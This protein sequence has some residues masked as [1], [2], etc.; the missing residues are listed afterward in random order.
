M[1]IK[2]KEADI[3][4]KM[5]VMPVGERLMGTAGEMRTGPVTMEGHPGREAEDGTRCHNWAQ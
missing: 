1:T 3:P 2:S 5:K 4:W